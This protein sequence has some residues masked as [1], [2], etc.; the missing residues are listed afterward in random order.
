MID[1]TQPSQTLLMGNGP[2][3]IMSD[4]GIVLS[5]ELREKL[6]AFATKHGISLQFE[7]YLSEGTSDWEYSVI[8]GYRTIPVGQP[9]ENIH[10]TTEMTL[11][12]DLE[13]LINFVI[14]LKDN[15]TELTL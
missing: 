11:V 5:I 7:V 6:K 14:L 3:I 10:S 12:S 1:V 2:A 8:E 4:P 15:F 9:I 13:Q